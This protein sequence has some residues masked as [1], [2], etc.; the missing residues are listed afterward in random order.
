MHESKL[1]PLRFS[2]I[3][4]ARREDVCIAFRRDSYVLSFGTFDGVESQMGP[5]NQ[6]Y[7]KHLRRFISQ[8]P[9]GNT[10]VWL[11]GEIIGQTEMSLVK[12]PTI[13]YVNLFY[14]VKA[15]RKQGLGAQLHTY[16]CNLF[17]A[18]GKSQLN[19]SVSPTN[20]PAHAFYEKHGWTSLGPRPNGANVIL[21]AYQNS[22]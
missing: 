19:L 10:H 20:L 4:L 13:G 17:R 12:D 3:D 21:M 14:L 5:D 6:T 18:K 15:C 2:P 9:E 11:N 1:P 16:A 7:L 22:I 8:V